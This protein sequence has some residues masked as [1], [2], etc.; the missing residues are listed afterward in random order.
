LETALG[1]ERLEAYHDNLFIRGVIMGG[2]VGGSKAESDSKASQKSSYSQD[3]WEKQSPYLE[4]LYKRAGDLFGTTSGAML[5]LTPEATAQQQQIFRQSMP[6]WGQQLGGGAYQ[7]VDPNNIIG[8]IERSMQRPSESGQ[9]YK[10]IMAGQGNVYV[11]GLKDQMKADAQDVLGR[12][13]SSLDARAAASGMGGGSRHGLAQGQAIE[14]VN[15]Q[16]QRDLTGVGYQSFDKDLANKLG[17]AEMADQNTLAR[18]QM[19][20]DMLG[21]KQA[22]MTGG[23]EGA[24]GM[25]QIGLGQFTPQMMPW[26]PMGA[27]QA[28]LGAPTILSSG[29]G[30]GSANSSSKSIGGGYSGGMGG[31]KG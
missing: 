2:S 4:D 5:G 6:A 30:Q 22:A 17:I 26:Q 14:D 7:S 20:T 21:Q 18:Q 16:L 15:R 28:A 24:T 23:L 8:S 11:G 9:L 1:Q 25:Q 31:G 12:S 19:L 10:D 3:V 29:Q 13:L 27:Y